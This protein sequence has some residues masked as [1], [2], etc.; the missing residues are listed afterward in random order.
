MVNT[1]KHIKQVKQ[2]ANGFSICRCLDLWGENMVYY[3]LYRNHIY[4]EGHTT[5][6]SLIQEYPELKNAIR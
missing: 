3:G 6:K 1:D 5:L 4:T 2:K